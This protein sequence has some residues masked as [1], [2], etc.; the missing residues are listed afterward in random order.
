MDGDGKKPLKIAFTNF[1]KLHINIGKEYTLKQFKNFGVHKTTIYKWIKKI[2]LRLK[3]A[4]F[5][6][7]TT[8]VHVA[9]QNGLQSLLKF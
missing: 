3:P 7:I 6:L 8:R 9:N 1:Y 5:G 4:R 2:E